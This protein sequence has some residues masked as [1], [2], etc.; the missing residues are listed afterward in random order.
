MVDLPKK[1]IITMI[2]NNFTKLCKINTIIVGNKRT[3]DNC[4]NF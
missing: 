2:N 4:S 3:Y 1:E